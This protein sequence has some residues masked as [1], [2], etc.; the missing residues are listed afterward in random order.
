MSWCMAGF[1]VITS[2]EGFVYTG[3]DNQLALF[4]KVLDYCWILPS[5]V[6]NGLHVWCEWEGT[7]ILLGVLRKL[8]HYG[9]VPPRPLPQQLGRVSPTALDLPRPPAI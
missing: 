8:L 1:N 9:L 3:E 4:G 7:E 6:P 2:M 5:K